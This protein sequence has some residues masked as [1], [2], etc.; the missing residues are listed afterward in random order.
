MLKTIPILLKRAI[1]ALA[2]VLATVL[3]IR[4][5][6]SQRGEP[7]E[8]WHTYVPH[9]L[10]AD[11]LERA[12]WA[13]YI[14]AENAALEEVRREVTD[15]LPEHDRV[16]FNRY[17]ADSP[18]NPAH[19]QQDWNRSYLL[20]PEGP[21]AGA[22]V[23]LHGLTDCPYSLRNV[24][25]S[26][27]ARGWAAVS[28]RLPGHGTVPAGLTDA[29]WEHWVEASRLAVR[30]AR[31]LA[32]PSAPLH[33][34][35]Y[36]NGGAL[37]LKYALDSLDDTALARPGRVVLI[38]PMIGVT[39]LARFAGVM[40]WP[41]V[42][43]AFAKAALLG[44][45]PEINPFSYNSFPVHAARQASQLTGVL[46]RQIVGHA[47]DGKLAQLPPIQTFQSVLDF[48]VSTRAIID[49]LYQYL[50]ANGSELVLFDLNHDAYLGPL[51]RPGK[52]VLVDRLLPAAPRPFRTAVI[53]N[54]G[55]DRREVSEEATEAGSAETRSRPLGLRYPREVYSL[56]HV[57][58]P[59]PPDDP[60]Y[61]TE[62]DRS[63]DF[64][65]RLGAMAARGERAALVVS[66]DLL[67]RMLSNPF[68]PYLMERIE[69]G[70]PSASATAPK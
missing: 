50:P 67:V 9:E 56:S 54:S 11:E 16:P 18:L 66:L 46:Q 44:V 14:A 26:Y 43:P 12:D 48:T 42:F 65:V 49:A 30:E 32:G 21:P 41:A 22:V 8:P 39:H 27:H 3:G 58:L 17:F 34:V 28:I 57:A 38:S 6:D 13:A 45:V 24:A 4:A 1:S 69:E 68:F 36:S 52:G 47:R 40:G 25:R 59:F 37:A 19:F 61:G 60:L 2:I 23:L 15:K 5:W 29:D 62:P 33:L 35:G 53:T 51:M 20:Q 64:G 10:H 55:G 7:L 31:R 70:I 63:E